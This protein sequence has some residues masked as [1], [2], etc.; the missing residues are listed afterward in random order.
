MLSDEQKQILLDFLHQHPCCVVSTINT[1]QEPE[2]ATVGFLELHTLELAFFTYDT[3]RKFK[4]LLT[5]PHIAVVVGTD[6]IIGKTL[7]YEGTARQMSTEE[8]ESYI[9]MYLTKN[10]AAKRFKDN[11]SK[12]FI[13]TPT[14]LRYTNIKQHP[15][16]VWE[17]TFANL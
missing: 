12:G 1:S 6:P 14:W 17:S 9:D 11:D 5:N 2:A 13:I 8:K 16:E 15:M 3:T 4:N 10:P 7:Q